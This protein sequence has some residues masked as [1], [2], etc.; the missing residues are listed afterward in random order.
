MTN[1]F[2]ID[3][4]E[5]GDAADVLVCRRMTQPLLM[6]DNEIGLCSRCGEAIQ[7]R[8]HVSPLPSKVCE[9]CIMPEIEQLGARGEL[10]SIITPET[11]VELGRYLRR[12]REH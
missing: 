8:P 4:G 6:P 7:F 3:D 9:V 2:E 11:A 10:H 1:S 12:K 5:N